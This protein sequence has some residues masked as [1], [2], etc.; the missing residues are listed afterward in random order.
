MWRRRG[1]C[2]AIED[3]PAIFVENEKIPP[4]ISVDIGTLKYRT[5]NAAGE[6]IGKRGAI[7]DDSIDAE[8]LTKRLGKEKKGDKESNENEGKACNSTG[9]H[10]RMFT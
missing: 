10:G 1:A 3:Q 4:S 9:V 8:I 5:V 2:V 7:P 6:R